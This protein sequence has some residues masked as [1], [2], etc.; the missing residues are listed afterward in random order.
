MKLRELSQDQLL[1]LKQACLCDIALEMYNE[2]PSIDMLLNADLY[3]SDS[4]LE[5]A[6]GATDFVTEDFVCSVAA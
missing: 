3:I 1:E 5:D 6:Y 2:T 4:D